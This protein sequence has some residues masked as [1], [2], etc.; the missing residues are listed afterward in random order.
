MVEILAAPPP[1]SA[2]KPRRLFHD[3]RWPSGGQPGKA[4]F[5]RDLVRMDATDRRRACKIISRRFAA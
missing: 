2:A 4:L 1:G 3:I 5:D